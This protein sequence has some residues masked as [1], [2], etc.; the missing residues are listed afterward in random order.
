[1]FKALGHL[2]RL[3]QSKLRRRGRSPE[4]P[5]H[6]RHW[7]ALH[8][9]CAGCGTVS[10]LQVH[11]IRPFHLFPELEL[12]YSNYLTLCMGQNE[13]HLRIGHGDNWTCWN[14]SAE[15][16]AARALAHPEMRKQIEAQAKANRRSTR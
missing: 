14:P 6:E 13:C 12:D 5:E 1:M 4:W 3:A 2:I 8:P 16:D 9:S 11:H 15:L 7:L 10:H